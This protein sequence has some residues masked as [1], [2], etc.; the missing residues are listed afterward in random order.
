VAKGAEFNADA[1]CLGK[2]VSFSEGLSTQ[3]GGCGDGDASVCIYYPGKDAGTHRTWVFSGNHAGLPD[4][5]KSF[6]CDP[7]TRARAIS[8]PR[9]E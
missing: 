6:P 7:E 5:I 1:G 3:E 4:H 2:S 9:C 8:A